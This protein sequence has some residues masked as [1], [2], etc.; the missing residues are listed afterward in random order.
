M[1][2]PRVSGRAVDRA[3]A[4]SYTLRAWRARARTR[5]AQCGG[6]KM[7]RGSLA[8]GVD[9]CRAGWIC[10][11][12]SPGGALESTCFPSAEA[13]LRQRPRPAALAID[14]PIGLPERGARDC[15]RAARAALGPRRSSVFPAPP[16]A[17]LAATSFEHACRLRERLEGRRI[18]KQSWFLL[19]K[20]REVDRALR[21]VP[22]RTRWVHEAH[23]ELCFAT[24]GGHPLC[25][26]KKRAAGRRERLALVARELGAGAFAALRARHPRG[27]V[28]D[29]DLL[30]ACA[31]LWTAERIL[32]GEAGR[33]PAAPPRDAHGL[34]MEIVY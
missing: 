11:R 12:R 25:H 13:L 21:R 14:V 4:P 31:A 2:P 16:R 19:A 6:G 34:R 10:V 17:L 18:S 15:D 23:P 1:R 20:I 9:G 30:D 33:L 27:D 7:R 24:W 26:A 28:A 8:A 29:D 3:A 5:A 22:S 32:R